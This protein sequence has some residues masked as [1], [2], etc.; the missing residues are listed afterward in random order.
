MTPKQS[1]GRFQKTKNLCIFSHWH[2]LFQ[3]IGIYLGQLVIITLLETYIDYLVSCPSQHTFGTETETGMVIP[4]IP[5][6]E[7]G[8]DPG[9]QMG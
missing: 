1:E 6:A 4:S 2:L 3:N 7:R 5:R 9:S 8:H